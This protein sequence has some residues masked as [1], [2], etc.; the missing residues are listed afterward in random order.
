MYYDKL[1]KRVHETVKAR[2]AALSPRTDIT[3]CIAPCYLPIHEDVTAG[4][5]TIYHLPGG[6]GSCKSSFVSLEIVDGIMR[7]Q[8]A[9]AIV[10]RRV[11]SSMRESVFTQISWAIDE[12]GVSALWR[13]NV[14]P[15]IFTY[16]P[17]GQQIHFRGLDDPAKLKSIKPRHGNFK[18]VW[19][20]E[21]AELP[22]ENTV[23]NTMQ[24]VVRGNGDFRIFC[25]FNPPLSVNNWANKYIL[26]PDDRAVVFRTDYTMIPHEWLGESFILEAERLKE[27][28]E[29]AYRHEYL[30]EPTGMGGEVFPQIETRTITDDEISQ[31]QYFYQGLDFGFSVDPACFIYVSYDKKHETV[32]LLDEIYQRHLSN[33]DLA[34]L[35]KAKNYNKTGRIYNYWTFPGSYEEKPTIICDAAEPKSISDL[36]TCGLRALACQKYPGSVQYGIKWLQSRKIVID[37]RR[38]PNAHREFTEYEY[39]QTK[40]GDF[41]ADVPDA[42]NHSIDAVR[43][44]L[45]RIINSAKNSA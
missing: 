44:A 28:N 4:A 35:I 18:F 7:D 38:T 41:L 15:M 19:Y 17:T 12:L 40:D 30:G 20:E 2:R 42:N 6:R 1:K 27:L 21:F 45:D 29:T 22:G 34:N 37:P 32:Y 10:F 25:S 14:S 24:S 11:A 31:M 33:T 5:H 36:K 43:Y 13:G 9:N 3:D 16:L 23:R 39:M 26:I 8:Y